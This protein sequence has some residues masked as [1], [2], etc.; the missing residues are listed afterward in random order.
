MFPFL[1]VSGSQIA[2]CLKRHLSAVVQPPDWPSIVATRWIDR[3]KPA[4][5][6]RKVHLL[7]KN[8]SW[9]ADYILQGADTYLADGL[10]ATLNGVELSNAMSSARIYVNRATARAPVGF[11]AGW[12]LQLESARS[13]SG[14]DE[15][16]TLV[17]DTVGS[18]VRYVIPSDHVVAKLLAEEI[19]RRLT[20]QDC[21]PLAWLAPWRWNFRGH[22]VVTKRILIVSEAETLYASKMQVLLTPR[23]QAEFGKTGGCAIPK[24]ESAD[25]LQGL[26]G[27]VGANPVAK[28]EPASAR[29]ATL[30]GAQQPS[31]GRSMLEY[32]AG[33][34]Q[35]DRA[36][37]LILQQGRI[38]EQ[39]LQEPLDAV[40]IIGSDVYDK[41]LLIQAARAA[42]PRA[43]IFTTDLDSRF[44]DPIEYPATRNL[45]VASGFDLTARSQYQPIAD[46]QFRDSYQTSTYIAVGQVICEFY[47]PNYKCLNT[48]SRPGVFEVG[49][50]GTIALS[51]SR[52]S[53]ASGNQ[54]WR[55]GR[56]LLITLAIAFVLF[57]AFVGTRYVYW[58]NDEWQLRRNLSRVGVA[59]AI[60]VAIYWLWFWPRANLPG[61][62]P[63]FLL[64]GVSI[65]PTEV[66]RQLATGTALV[67][68]AC[69]VYDIER[70]N[71]RIELRS[72]LL[73]V[74]SK[75]SPWPKRARWFHCWRHASVS[76]WNQRLTQSTSDGTQATHMPLQKVWRD[77]RSYG[78]P[79]AR[80]LRV[81]TILGV[82]LLLFLL[83]WWL[84]SEE[85]NS[86]PARA[87]VLA[88]DPWTTYRS[89]FFA[90][91]VAV[92][93]GVV[94]CLLCVS[95]VIDATQL[96]STFVRWWATSSVHGPRQLTPAQLMSALQVAGER[97][98]TVGRFVIYPFALIA[99]LLISRSSYFDQ[100]GW[101][102]SFVI[103]LGMVAVYALASAWALRRAAE[104]MRLMLVENL[105]CRLLALGPIA[106]ADDIKAAIEFTS[107]YRTGAFSEW[108]RNPLLRALLIP[109]GGAGLVTAL[110][111]SVATM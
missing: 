59:I 34:A 49:R 58:I 10:L 69:M 65:W 25:Y 89:A 5:Q 92:F 64:E 36:K 48:K 30:L 82:S 56:L 23:L 20:P 76:A 62:E 12:Y 105:Q 40:V 19:R 7:R 79:M 22:G 51:E 108:F 27:E 97:T 75:V 77:Y 54:A 13:G 37:D 81:G 87:E 38:D 104:R 74:I 103:V 102:V 100:W 26:D 39:G 60:Y 43:L 70:S 24:I 50:T 47:R 98:A 66:F 14:E 57:F 86:V 15:S 46:M 106:Q 88:G 95:Y 32:P 80:R 91:A 94:S 109:A 61:A 53:R 41:L 16:N 17:P 9:H 71:E 28:S 93:I 67:F 6:G 99:I 83:I 21:G 52:V 107:A 72:P 73:F 85:T 18:S 90:N 101:P 11:D 2:S 68:M 111:D 78:H 110:L 84:A 63:F 29:V 96:S 4:V 55:A 45:V 44:L 31:S 8:R 33:R 1:K 3:M 35:L 42:A